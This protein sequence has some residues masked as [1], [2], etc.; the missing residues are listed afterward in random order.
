[1]H[2]HGVSGMYESELIA[3]RPHGGCAILWKKSLS[4]KITPIIFQSNRVSAISFQ[5]DN[6]KIMMVNVYM[7]CESVIQCNN[8]MEFEGILNEISSK[9]HDLDMNSIVLGDD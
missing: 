4:C 3:G 9:L 1:M 8:S 7:N 5:I 6:F 2:V